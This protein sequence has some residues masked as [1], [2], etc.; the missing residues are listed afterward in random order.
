MKIKLK[1]ESFEKKNIIYKFL[2]HLKTSK[3]FT[4]VEEITTLERN[5]YYLYYNFQN[6]QILQICK[7]NKFHKFESRKF[8]ERHKILFARHI[9]LVEMK[10]AF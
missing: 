5:L 2:R 8:T 7:I 9:R 6:V 4:N 3:K 1:Y 10:I